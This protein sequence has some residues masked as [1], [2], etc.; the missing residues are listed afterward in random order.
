MSV[1]SY[2]IQFLLVSKK[3]TKVRKPAL[4]SKIYCYLCTIQ[5]SGAKRQEYHRP[6][7]ICRTGKT[8]RTAPAFRP[9]E[10]PADFGPIAN[11]DQKQNHERISFHILVVETLL[12]Q[13]PPEHAQCD[14]Q[15]RGVVHPH[16]PG[17]SAR[18]VSGFRA[19]AFHPHSVDRGLYAGA[20][21][22]ARL[23][24]RS[25]PLA[26]KSDAKRHPSGFHGADDERHDYL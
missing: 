23:P 11:N 25:G 13:T 1:L 5:L 24:R 2:Y 20:G 18:R 14:R 9:A 26:R 8:K 17:R 19:A 22:P 16:L 6:R 15:R 4:N 10:T 21:T 12:P 7:S 3:R